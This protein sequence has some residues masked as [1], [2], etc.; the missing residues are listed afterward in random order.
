[1]PFIVLH[2]IAAT[3]MGMRNITANFLSEVSAEFT[4][5]CQSVI[6]AFVLQEIVT[7]VTSPCKQL[8]LGEISIVPSRILHGCQCDL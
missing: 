8:S 1:M 6:N 2:Q 7:L 3:Y 5:L 4:L